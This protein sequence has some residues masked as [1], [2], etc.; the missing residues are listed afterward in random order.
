MP[1]LSAQLCEDARVT[2]YVRLKLG[3]PKVYAALGCIAVLASFVPMPE[4][5][6]YKDNSAILWQNNVRLADKAVACIELEAKPHS[7]NSATD[8][9]LG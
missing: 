9:A 7:M 4:A 3:L 5:A 6:V 2:F 8:N 1:A